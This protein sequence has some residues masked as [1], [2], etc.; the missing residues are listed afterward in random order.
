MHRVLERQ[1]RKLGLSEAP[2]DAAQWRA[3]L[4]RVDQ[5]YTS[6]D[7]D[8]YTLERALDLS[9]GEMRKRFAELR[10]AQDQLVLASRKAGMA[11]VATSVLHNVGN[12]LNSVN[13]AANLVSQLAKSTTRAGLGKSLTLL[14]AQPAPGRFLD[15]DPRGKKLL[16]YL[17]AIDR[18]L[19]EEGRQMSS[20]L[21]NLSR[22]IDHIKAIVAQQLAV[23]RG[24]NQALVEEQIVLGQLLD[25]AVL[26]VKGSLPRRSAITFVRDYA[27]CVVRAD[28]HKLFQI[29]L[30][31]LANAR[32]ALAARP[33]GTITLRI[34]SVESQARVDV[35]DD[36]VGI[37]AENLAEIFTHGFTTKPTGN[38]FGL[39]SSACAAME[40]GGNLSV[41][42]DGVG[43]GARLTLCLPCERPLSKSA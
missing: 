25:D 8:R 28:R 1:L 26:V 42:S 9:S 30:N 34:H 10:S 22:H 31:L 37:A 4:E 14:R 18:T 15:D 13:V 32:D 23:A 19:G 27:P 17:D 21:E 12:V 11:D 33:E 38:G 20:E 16:Q 29:V 35:E 41:H 2:P 6:A 36:G 40:L 3:F 39:H 5:S 24:G 43:R 7:Q